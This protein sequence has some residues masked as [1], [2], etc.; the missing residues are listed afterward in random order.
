M[1]WTVSGEKQFEVLLRANIF[2]IRRHR[3]KNPSFSTESTDSRRSG[4]EIYPWL[5]NGGLRP[6]GDIGAGAGSWD[7]GT[8]ALM[9]LRMKF[10][11][12]N[13]EVDY[14]YVSCKPHSRYPSYTVSTSLQLNAG[15]QYL[16]DAVGSA[17]VRAVGLEG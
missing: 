16:S 17:R 5:P 9:Q 13:Y 11:L 4:D 14:L 1:L 3:P 7:S 12:T 10:T 8:N 6:E 2:V 15:W